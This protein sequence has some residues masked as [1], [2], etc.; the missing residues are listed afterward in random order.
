[1]KASSQTTLR[2]TVTLAGNGVHSGK[3]VRLTIHPAEVNH[4]IVFLRTGLANGRERLIEARHVAV[5]ATELCTRIGE[6]ES[7]AVATIEHLMSAL[8]GLGIDNVLI[9]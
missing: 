8:A 2:D 3:P 9:E 5:S 4:G 6:S 7:G 1:M